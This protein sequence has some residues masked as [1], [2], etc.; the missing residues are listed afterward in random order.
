MSLHF[1]SRDEG[2]TFLL[3]ADN[4]IQD[5]KHGLA[6]EKSQLVSSTPSEP[7][8]SDY[9]NPA[10]GSKTREETEHTRKQMLRHHNPVGS[11]N[12]SHNIRRLK[13]ML[14]QLNPLKPKLIQITV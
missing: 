2:N 1:N 10:I 13:S 3:S 14:Q 7:Q 9:E 11:Q 8:I 4:Y 5:N 6:S 12:N